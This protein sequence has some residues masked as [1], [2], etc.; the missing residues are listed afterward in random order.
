M[1]IFEFSQDDW[2]GHRK[3]LHS[4]DDNDYNSD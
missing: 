2:L 4:D 1:K 3:L